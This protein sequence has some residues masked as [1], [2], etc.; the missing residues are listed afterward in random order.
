MIIIKISIQNGDKTQIQGQV[1]TPAS[2][3][4]INN[5]AKRSKKLTPAVVAEEFL[6]ISYN[7]FLSLQYYYIIFFII[8][9]LFLILLIEILYHIFL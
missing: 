5:T 1:I 9:Q 7:T 8:F 6:S 2:F 3:N 4:P